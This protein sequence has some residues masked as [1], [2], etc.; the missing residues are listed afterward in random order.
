[1]SIL[2]YKQRHRHPN[3]KGTPGA[4]YA[5]VRY[6][7][8]RSGVIKNEGMEHGLFGKMEPGALTCF[9]DWRDVAKQ[10]YAAAKKGRIM[11]RSVVSF[12]PQTAKEILLEEQRDWQRYIENHILTIAGKNGIRREHLKWAAAVHGE[13]DHP[14]L[15]V[16]FWDSSDRVRSPFTPPEVPDAIRKQMIKDTFSEKILAYAKEKDAAAGG[17][18]RITDELVQQFENAMRRRIPE[19]YR[20]TEQEK[21]SGEEPETN[22]FFSEKMLFELV[23]RMETLRGGLPKQGRLS[24]RLLPPE[25]KTAVDALAEYLLEEVPQL[26]HFFDRYVEAKCRMASLYDA[27]EADGIHSD[28]YRREAGKILGNSILS[29]IKMLNRLEQ[30]VM[31]AACREERREHYACMIL[32]EILGALAQAAHREE[33]Y[34]AFRRNGG[35]L[36]KEARKELFLKNQDK[37]YEH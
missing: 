34:A 27:G 26:R 30:E 9:A 28:K 6:I 4:D 1:M 33:A 25:S 2:V 17:I 36:S 13:K 5:H 24:Y 8:T 32:L 35:E 18:R 29:G 23:R 14:H 19:K 12:A 3:R 37:G 31:T 11:Y 15:H 7:A 22:L 16:V 10:A 20:D 21:G